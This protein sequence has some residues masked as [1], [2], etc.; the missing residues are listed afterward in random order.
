ML[1]FQISIKKFTLYTDASAL[2]LG[3]VIMQHK[4]IAFYSRKLT[5]TQKRYG[6]GEIDQLCITHKN[7]F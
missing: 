5:E 7:E 1:A 3:P 6:V 2:Q 4:P